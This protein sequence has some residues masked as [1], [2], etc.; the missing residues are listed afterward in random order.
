MNASNSRTPRHLSLRT[1]L[2]ALMVPVVL[3]CSL[4]IGSG[5]ASGDVSHVG[6]PHTVVVAFASNAGGRMVGTDGNDML[7]GGDSNDR[8]YG[9]P[10][11]DVIWGDR[12]PSPNGANQTDW[13]YGGTGDNWIYASH[14]TNHIFT[15][16]DDNHVFAYFGRGTIDCGAGN[17]VVTLSKSS[18]HN[19]TWVNCKD[20]VIGY[21]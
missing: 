20:I 6:W 7:L 21:P 11:N 18:Y 14:G 2:L 5:S 10:G 12:F 3:V 9:G 13:L 16:P 19:Y 15:G 17:D 1:R 8:I 4:A